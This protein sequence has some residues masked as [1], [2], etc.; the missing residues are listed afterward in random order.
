[1][2]EAGQQALMRLPGHSSEQVV[3]GRSSVDG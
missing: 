1:L 2:R 3:R